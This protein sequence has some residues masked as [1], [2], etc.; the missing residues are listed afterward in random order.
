VHCGMRWI[1]GWVDEEERH[2]GENE[3]EET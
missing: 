1:D 2:A 3:D